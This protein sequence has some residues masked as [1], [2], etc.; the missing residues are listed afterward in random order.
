VLS[1]LSPLGERVAR[2]RRFHQPGRAG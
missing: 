2:R 1:A